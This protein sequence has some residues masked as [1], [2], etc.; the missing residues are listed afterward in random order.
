MLYKSFR[1]VAGVDVI[2]AYQLN[3]Y[4]VLRS[5]VLVFTEPA[6]KR[7]QEVFGS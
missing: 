5:Q 2:P 6:L 4:R 1:N 7:A 3:A